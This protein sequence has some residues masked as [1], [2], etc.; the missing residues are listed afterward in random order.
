MF[1]GLLLVLFLVFSSVASYA[2][3]DFDKDIVVLNQSRS[4]K[5]KAVF[6]ELMNYYEEED[7]QGFFSLVSEDRFLQDFMLFSEAIEKD[8]RLY[9][10]LSFDYWI[11]KITD[12]GV[13]R[14]LYVKW[15]KR[16]QANNQATEQTKTGYSRFLFD[17]I[18]GKYKLIELAGNNLWGDSLD[19][20][21]EE[22]PEIPGQ[23]SE[24]ETNSDTYP[25][26]ESVD[27]NPPIEEVFLP[28]LVIIESC[29]NSG[30]F[31]IKNQGEGD[32]T[33]G[34]I[35]YSLTADDGQTATNIY[36]ENLAA[37]ETSSEIYCDAVSSYGGTIE[38]DPNNQIEESNEDN[39][40]AIVSANEPSPVVGPY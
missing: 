14:Y 2:Q 32:T 39:N 16:F 33:S 35:E 36:E 5:V 28:D 38:V 3:S 25:P 17:E 13:K 26:S 37:G 6:K 12:D 9:D 1:K 24:D 4:D 34:Y 22:V 7:E 11:D 21:K 10:I 27:P 18:N 40:K 19:E 8:F 15:E 30:T 23:E 20:W 31:V 29:V